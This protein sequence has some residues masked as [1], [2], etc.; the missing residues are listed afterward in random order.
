M[1]LDGT[2][3]L[4]ND[5]FVQVQEPS[6]IQTG[7]VPAENFVGDRFTATALVAEN[8]LAT[9]EEYIERLSDLLQELDQYTPGPIDVDPPVITPITVLDRPIPDFSGGDYDFPENDAVKPTLSPY[10]EIIPLDPPPFNAVKPPASAEKPELEP[11]DQPGGSPNIGIIPIPPPPGYT[12]PDLPILADI[13]IP[14][15][16]DIT[17]PPWEGDFVDEL[18]PTPAEFNWQESPFNSDIWNT[19]LDKTLEKLNDEDRY[20]HIMKY[21]ASIDAGADVTM[22]DLIFQATVQ[23]EIEELVALYHNPETAIT[24]EKYLFDIALA[25]FQEQIDRLDAREREEFGKLTIMQQEIYDRAREQVRVANDKAYREVEEY[26]AAR[27]FPLPPGAM[28]GRLAEVSQEI[29]RNERDIAGKI[30]IDMSD[31]RRKDTYMLLELVQ[32][33]VHKMLDMVQKNALFMVENNQK[34]FHF[35]TGTNQEN[36]RFM[37]TAIQQADQFVKKLNNDRLQFVESTNSSNEQ[38]EISTNIKNREFA[39]NYN[40]KD[41]L[42]IEDLNQKGELA[43]LDANIKQEQFASELS[44]QLE[45]ILREFHNAQQNR[46]LE[47]AKAIANHSIQIVNAYIARYNARIEKYKAD[48]MVYGEQ[49]KALQ[50]EVE[51]F[52]AQIEGAKI[53]AEVQKLQVD[54]YTA[55]VNAIKVLAEF[56]SAQMEAAKIQAD[57]ERLKIDVFKAE[58]EVYVAKLQGQ[59]II[60]EIYGIEVEA[61]KV[62]MQGYAEEIRAYV[63][64]IEA[65]KTQ[66]EVLIANLEAKTKTNLAL[67][68]EYKAELQAYGIETDVVAKQIEADTRIYEA[69]VEGYKAETQAYSSYY[70]VKIAEINNVIQQARFNLELEV[71]KVEST[72][73]SYIALKELEV[74]GTEGV[75]SVTAQLAASALSAVNASASYGFSGSRSHGTSWSFSASAQESHSFLHDPVE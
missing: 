38:F 25:R 52:K 56:Y 28:A 64:Q 41:R 29:S 75:M 30:M 70:G 24:L 27:N 61:D 20:T 2:H 31:Q 42:T 22:Q 49:L 55:Q 62:R 73:K 5:T 48:A 36:A 4:D 13:P 1:A 39:E 21:A 54:I 16:P 33:D 74:K 60:A 72:S 71:A 43:I 6:S 59:K 3:D 7:Q 63:S 32:K 65:Q 50:V 51:I 26:F 14:S 10:D 45:I 46:S 66:M 8:A 9:T 35:I 69:E 40:Q 67:I 58:V 17:I 44:R 11:I 15:A 68:E 47:A 12:E 57:I 19:L 18:L 34:D 37:I 53:T 23:R